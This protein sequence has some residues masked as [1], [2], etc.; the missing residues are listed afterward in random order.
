LTPKQAEKLPQLEI[1]DAHGLATSKEAPGNSGGSSASSATTSKSIVIALQLAARQSAEQRF[2]SY[3]EYVMALSDR[4]EAAEA[5]YNKK[6]EKAKAPNNVKKPELLMM[7]SIDTVSK[8]QKQRIGMKHYSILSL[9]ECISLH[10][11]CTHL[12][13]LLFCCSVS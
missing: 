11:V 8:L 12:C 7:Q 10:A 4:K 6:R 2:G 9:S 5:K 13:L 1:N 3:D